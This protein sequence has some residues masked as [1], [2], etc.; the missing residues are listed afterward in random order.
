MNDINNMNDKAV[1][2][3]SLGG[4]VL[5]AGKVKNGKVLKGLRKKI[6]NKDSE[7]SIIKEIVSAVKELIDDEV[8]GI[9]FG[10][11]SLVDVQQGIVYN[12]QKI[13]SWKEV[14]IK[15]I[16]EDAFGLQIYVNNDAN[17]FATGELYFGKGQ[18]CKNLVALVLG[19]GVGAGIVF[20]EHLYSGSN[21]GAGEF[22]NVPYR[23]HDLEYYLSEAYFEI[24]YGLNLETLLKRAAKKDKIALA[25]FEQ[26]GFDLGNAIKT[27]M[28]TIDP[29]LIIL[30][31][32]ISRAFEYFKEAMW[33]KVHT[34]TYPR[35]VQNL[36]IEASENEHIAVLGAAALYFDARNN[37][38][39]KESL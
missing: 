17:C 2:G 25:V 3:I 1:I 20:N 11:P 36:R 24:K 39:R 37:V 9:G 8:V 31:G 13:K 34:F 35:S 6:N 5:L 32:P 21:C 10:A 38:L 12:V 7:D 30:G 15:E 23:H 4:G 14:H 18:S 28:Y 29:E 26:Y 16:L 19:V 33:E 27:I 22:G